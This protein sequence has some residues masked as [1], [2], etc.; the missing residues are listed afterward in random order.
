ML[1]VLGQI[2]LQYNKK[3]NLAAQI[4]LNWFQD[5]STG[6][7][8]VERDPVKKFSFLFRPVEKESFVLANMAVGNDNVTIAVQNQ[9]VS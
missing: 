8:N 2:N 1:N 3:Y 9:Q 4:S 7:V 5:G 6:F